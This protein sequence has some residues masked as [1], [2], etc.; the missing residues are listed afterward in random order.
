MGANWDDVY[1]AI[2]IN[3]KI[4]AKVLDIEIIKK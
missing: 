1:P 4:Q 3:V 2:Y